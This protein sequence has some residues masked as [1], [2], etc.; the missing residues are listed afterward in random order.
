[1]CALCVNF[2]GYLGDLEYIEQPKCNQQT[3]GQINL[4]LKQ[5]ICFKEKLFELKHQTD[6][7]K[8]T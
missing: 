8:P 5:A 6:M 2:E 7:A 1:M 4:P 3:Y